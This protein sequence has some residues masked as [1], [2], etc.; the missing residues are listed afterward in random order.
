MSREGGVPNYLT[1]LDLQGAVTLSTTNVWPGGPTGFNL[2]GTNVTVS[3]WDEASPRLNHIEFDARIA[4]FDGNTNL[5]YHSTGVAGVLA[6]AG[7][8]LFFDTNS[9]P[10]GPLA[11]GMAFTAQVQARDTALDLG[12]MTGAVGTNHMRLS[13]HSYGSFQGWAQDNTGLWYWFGNPEISGTEDPKFGNYTTNATRYDALI[14]SAPTYLSVWAA[15]NSLS[16]GPPVQPTNHVEFNL[17]GTGYF[18]N[19]VR[20]RDGDAGGFDSLE[21]QACAKNTLSVGAIFPLANGFTGPT[22]VFLAPFSSCGPTDDGRI[23]PDVVADGINNITPGAG[24]TN[25]YVQWPGGTSF[26]APAIA[27]SAGLLSQFYKQLHPNSSKPLASTLKG[28]VI[29]TAD[30]CTTNAGPSYRFGWGV[31]N[32]RSAAT[33]MNQDATNGLKNQIKEVL[34]N[35]GMTIQF[36]VVSA[37]ATNNPLKVTICWTDPAGAPNSVTNLDNSASKLVN[38]LDLRVIAPN[39]TTNL[40]WVLNP[41]LTNQTSAARS[42][43]ATTGDDNRNNVEQ[44]YIA[45]PTN[46][47][48]TVTVTHKASLTNDQWVSILIS[49]NVPQAMP[50]LVINQFVQTSTNTFA[51]GWPAVVGAQYQLQSNGD[52]SATNWAN[53]D[54]IISARLTNVVTQVSFSQTNIAQ[55]F[56]VVQVP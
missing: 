45:R 50:P 3:M 22:N 29:H 38:D 16:N 55:F 42:A 47:A 33:L 48:Y 52:V 56:R 14:Q 36:P 35:D 40:P 21:Q 6:A 5:S 44:V 15:G 7:T 13:N 32:T 43:V 27:G 20:P 2:N 30:S 18:T 11:K 34:L 23:K 41:D 8:T 24:A 12:E 51:I 54:G 10:L 37:D 17:A 53:V 26:A 39:G 1:P 19:A 4:E 46:G 28:L 25:E 49:G 31:M 9:Q